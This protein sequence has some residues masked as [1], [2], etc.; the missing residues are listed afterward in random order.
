MDRSLRFMTACAL[1]SLFTACAAN[2]GLAP[3]TRP[4][5]PE[6]VARHNADAPPNLQIVCG[7]LYE[8]GSHFKRRVCWLRQELVLGRNH[9]D[10]ILVSTAPAIAQSPALG[11]DRADR[12]PPPEDI[13]DL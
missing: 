2:P 6:E 4:P 11:A 12:I 13:L 10:Q 5:T 9:R 8:T 1:L 7:N 3:N